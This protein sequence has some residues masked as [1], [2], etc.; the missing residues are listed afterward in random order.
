[1]L[2]HT[3]FKW[4]V[5]FLTSLFVLCLNISSDGMLI[6]LGTRGL[7]KLILETCHIRSPFIGDFL[8][9]KFYEFCPLCGYWLS[10][11]WLNWLCIYS[12]QAVFPTHRMNLF[13]KLWVPW[14]FRIGCFNAV[15]RLISMQSMGQCNRWHSKWGKWKK[16]K[17]IVFKGFSTNKSVLTLACIFLIRLK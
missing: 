1:M 6:A 17:P 3:H 13:I 8:K 15:S 2:S 5:I 14:T 11:N 16:P 7:G 4:S 10:R 9:N 12:L